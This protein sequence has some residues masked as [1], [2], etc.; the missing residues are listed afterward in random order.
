MSGT[1]VFGLIFLLVSMLFGDRPNVV[2]IVSDDQAWTDYGF[3]GHPYVRTPNLD[4]LAKRSLTFERGYVAAPLCRPSLASLVTGLFPIQHGIAGNDVDGYRQRALLDEKVQRKF[5]QLPS[6]IRRLSNAGYMTHQSGKWWEGSWRDGG[7]THGMT[8]G[9]PKRNG[10]HGDEGLAI[11]RQGMKPVIEFIEGAI[12]KE[13]PFFVWYAPFLPHTPH[14]PPKHRLQKYQTASI[15]PDVARY[16]AMCE[17][18]DETC[19]EL[20][21]HLKKRRIEDQTMVVYIADNGWAAPSTNSIDPKQEQWRHYALRSKSSPFENGVRTPILISWPQIVQPERS[22]RLAHAIDIFPTISAATGIAVPENLSGINLLD[23]NALAQRQRVF[24][25]THSTHNMN[26]D[27]PDETLQ[28][29]WCVEER[30]K[31][32]IRKHGADTTKYKVLHAWDNTPV[33]LYDLQVDPH[34]KNDVS[35]K[36][37]E[38][39]ERLH[40]EIKKWRATL[41]HSQKSMPADRTGARCR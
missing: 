9:D 15:Q 8:H 26:P 17:W 2:L 30:W 32:I 6:L 35:K 31:L 40:S 34:E 38:V 33:R 36:H 39:V 21:D 25:V 3:M 13:K 1:A 19:G 14:N 11:G 10:R 24:G 16:F 23:S 27:D 5:H 28:Y 18:F 22:A 7:F 20:L 37:P 41:N 12:R 4:R 29:L